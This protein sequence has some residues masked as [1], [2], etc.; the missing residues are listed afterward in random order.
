[1]SQE[2]LDFSNVD[3][4]SGGYLS[5]GVYR[6]KPTAVEL[7]EAKEVGKN[8]SLKF[9]F[10]AVTEGY[11]GYSVDTNFF[12]TQKALPRLQYLHEKYFGIK[13][14]NKS[15]SF[16]DLATYFS[17]K[18]LP[19]PKSFL[20]V[21]GGSESAKDGKIYADIPYADFIIDEA[22]HP[23]VEEGPYEEGSAAYNKVIRK[24]KALGATSSSAAVMSNAGAGAAAEDWKAP[25]ELDNQ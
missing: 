4:V 10:E 18:M 19:K 12:L 15:I 24:Q 23:D 11:E 14:E 17:K 5:P 16:K 7:R 21:V 9:T 20:L 2:T 13:L 22:A 6:V 1:M 3:S 8:S 25:W